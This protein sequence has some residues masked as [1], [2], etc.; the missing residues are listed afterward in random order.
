M[1]N[2]WTEAHL[3]IFLFSIFTVE[4]RQFNVSILTASAKRAN[5]IRLY[6]GNLNY[7]YSMKVGGAQA[8]D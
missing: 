5:P 7:M 6:L 3:T 4:C 8:E 2:G 1:H